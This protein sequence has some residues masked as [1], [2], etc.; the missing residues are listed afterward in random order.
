[1]IDKGTWVLIERT[2]LEPAE[3]AP[4]VPEDTKAVPLKMWVKGALAAD[5]AIGDTVTVRTRTGR[6]ET[7]VLRETG[8][9]YRH[10]FGD[11]VPELLAINEQVRTILFGGGDE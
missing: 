10:D 11:F 6:I 5:A 7:G 2:I 3:R 8:P 1:M 4:Q 9:S